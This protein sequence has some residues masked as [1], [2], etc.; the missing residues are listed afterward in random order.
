LWRWLRLVAAVGLVI[1]PA[2][3]GS[4]AGGSWPTYH[5]DNNRSGYDST[6]PAYSAVSKAWSAA[7]D[8][9][10]Y[11]EPLVSGSTVIAATENN[12]VYAYSTGG[13]QLWQRNLGNPVPSSSLPCGNINPV[14]ITSTPVIDTSANRVL[15]VAFLSSPNIHYKLVALDLGTGAVAWQTTLSDSANGFD[16]LVEN[17]RGALTLANGNVYVPFGGRAGDCGSYR[18]WVM[19]FPESGS[20]TLASVPLPE[21][22]DHEGGL[23]QPAGGSTDGS[24]NLYYASGNT[25]CGSSCTYDYGESVIKF[26]PTLG[27]LGS[28]YPTNWESLNASDA[29]LGSTGPLQLADGYVFQVGKTGVG[30]VVSE[31]ALNAGPMQ[32]AVFSGTAC[33]GG[34]GAFGGDAFDGVQIYVPCTNGVEALT[35]DHSTHH[36]AMSWHAAGIYDPPIV[37][38]GYVWVDANGNLYGLN[39]GNGQVAFQVALSASS[40]HFGT[41]AAIGD[42]IFVPASSTLVA[43]DATVATNTGNADR[44]YTLDGYGGLHADGAAPVP[45]GSAYWAGWD[46]A[47]GIAEFPDGSGGY[48]LDGWGGVHPF[49]VGGAALPATPVPGGYWQD[50]DIARGIVL[51]PWATASAP[52]GYELDGWGGVHPFGGAPAVG[53]NAYWPGWGIARG[54]VLLPDSTPTSVGGYTLDG[55]GGIHPFGNAP[56]VSGAP[57]WQGWDIG[58]GI[59]LLPT[60]THSAPAGYI[61][62]GWGGVHPFGS[63]SGVGGY[64]YWAGWDIARAVVL[65][66]GAGAGAPGG[67]TLDGWGGIHAFG[68]AP[69]L[70]SGANWR[71]WDIARGLGASGES[72]GARR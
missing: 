40:S 11:A 15:V 19:S 2:I 42:Q 21:G 23:W 65:W 67:W 43:V 71:G 8:G 52:A 45:T 7:L 69:A 51:A 56:D 31:A 17:Q 22:S 38:G 3:N 10:L 41:P 18:G 4:A 24:G 12:S 32:T 9:A 13:T 33:P 68:S 62:D 47:R 66:T 44:V 49:A 5:A 46:I 20:G 53:G 70:A 59:V 27:I 60:A 50:W 64:A 55:W 63:A 6:D 58:R 39:P 28:F 14:G 72:S 48:T 36:F 16:P 34:A 25:S 29:D 1:A 54:I 61:L 30:F 26:S 57:Y 37:A 35:Y